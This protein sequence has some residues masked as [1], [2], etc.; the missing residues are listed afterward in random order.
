MRRWF[1]SMSATLSDFSDVK[2]G[3]LSFISPLPSS[4]SVSL[5]A[6]LFLLT[7]FTGTMVEVVWIVDLS[8]VGKP[9]LRPRPREDE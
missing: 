3:F 2:P 9:K 1:V 5:S 6:G 7:G 8:L 4:L